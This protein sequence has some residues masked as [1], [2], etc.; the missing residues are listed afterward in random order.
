[1]LLLPRL[2]HFPTLSSHKARPFSSLY[3]RLFASVNEVFLLRELV[4]RNQ[5][6]I[7]DMNGLQD[8]ASRD[9]SKRILTDTAAFVSYIFQ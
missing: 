7:L 6:R 4:S 2:L 8:K 3:I 1:M 9:I 5:S